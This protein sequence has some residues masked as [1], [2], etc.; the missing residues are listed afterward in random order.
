MAKKGNAQ[1]FSFLMNILKNILQKDYFHNF[2][3]L[4]IGIETLKRQFSK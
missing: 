2:I 3:S 4:S 1:K